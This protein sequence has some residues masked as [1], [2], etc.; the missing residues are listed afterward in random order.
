MQVES[1]VTI[2]Q[3]I[4][5]VTATK[6]FNVEVNGARDVVKE[7]PETHIGGSAGEIVRCPQSAIDMKI[8]IV[9]SESP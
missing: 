7:N 5:Q 1:G 3:Q 8:F 4:T 6:S 9:L 2:Q